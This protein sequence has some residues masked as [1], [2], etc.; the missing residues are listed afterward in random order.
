MVRGGHF[1]QGEGT[2]SSADIIPRYISHITE[3]C[4]ID[5]TF[6]LVIDGANSV[7]GP[8]ALKLFDSLGCMAFP[9]YCTVDGAFPKD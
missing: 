8:I 5:E 7:P 6:K 9:L 3:T 2:L 1:A 4:V